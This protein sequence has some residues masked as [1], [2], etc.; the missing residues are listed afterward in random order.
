MLDPRIYRTGFI[1]VALALVV[2][3]FSLQ[4][5][6]GPAGTTLAP[7]A[8]NGPAAYQTMT[9]LAAQYPDRLPGSVDDRDLATEVAQDFRTANRAFTVS[10]D[11]FSGRTVDGT[12]TLANV[13]AVLPGINSG[14][15]VVIAH[16]DSL[17]SPSVAD[18]SGTA[19]LIELE[20]DRT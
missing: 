1:V 6:P 19:T 12:R 18:L 3:A 13:T 20:G 9:T 7:E 15:V 11:S 10:I 14:S 16:R 17:A 2:L 4:N 5:Q 8:F